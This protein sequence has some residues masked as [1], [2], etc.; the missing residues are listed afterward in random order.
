MSSVLGDDYTFFKLYNMLIGSAIEALQPTRVN[1]FDEDM[2]ELM[3][4]NEAGYVEHITSDPSW[5]KFFISDQLEG[6]ELQGILFEVSTDWIDNVKKSKLRHE[7]NTSIQHLLYNSPESAL[8]DLVIKDY[9]GG[10][11][12]RVSSNDIIVSWFWDLVQPTVGLL[13]VNLREQ[14]QVVTTNHAGNYSN[15]IAYTPEDYKTAERIQKS[16]SS[17]CRVGKSFDPP[18]VLPRVR[19]N[20]RFSIV[21]N[22]L[23]FSQPKQ[24]ENEAYGSEKTLLDNKRFRLVRHTP[25]YFAS[26]LK[27][28]LTKRMSFLDLFQ[29]C[30]NKIAC[31]IVAPPNAISKINTCGIVNDIIWRF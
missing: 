18:T 10:I 8:V 1:R 29:I 15:S 24:K 25:L 26:E 20:T 3:G 14:I 27:G 6:A 19:V 7:K 5:E 4:P 23:S 12:K 13:E 30:H 31:F 2:S 11:V 28:V 22:R 17:F 9:N 16:Q 21:T